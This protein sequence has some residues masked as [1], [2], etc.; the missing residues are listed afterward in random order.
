MLSDA[1]G[2]RR[3]GWAGL[4]VH[5]AHCFVVGAGSLLATEPLQLQPLPA[6][7]MAGVAP[8]SKW[9]LGAAGPFFLI[10]WQ[11]HEDLNSPMRCEH[12]YYVGYP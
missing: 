2:L 10:T 11:G 7:N 4:A 8:A 12:R 6:L 9:L 1:G 3:L 5:L